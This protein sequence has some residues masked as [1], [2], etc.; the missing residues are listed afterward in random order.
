MSARPA[1]FNIVTRHSVLLE[2]LKAHQTKKLDAF[3]REQDKAIRLALTRDG[4][5]EFKRDRLEALLREV[6]GLLLEINL[7]YTDTLTADLKALSA[8]E[9]SFAVKALEVTGLN[10]V[11]PTVGQLW[12]AA[13]TDPLL[14]HGANKGKLL[15][16]FI[17]DWSSGERTAVSNAIRAAVAQGQTIGETV[18]AIR[19]TEAAG[20]ADGLLSIQKR[21]A[22]AVVRTAV[23]HVGDAS[24]R[25]TYGRN[26]DIVKGEQ[27]SATLDNRTTDIC[28]SL[29]GRVF[30]LD[31]GPRPPAH[32]N[33][34]SVMIPVLNDEFAFLSKGGKRSSPDGPVDAKL[35]YFEWLKTQDK[36]FQDSALG[37]ARATLFREGGLSADRFAALQLDRNFNPLT[38]AEMRTLEPL[39]FDRAG[40]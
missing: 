31:K 14:V 21:Q 4:L 26:A 30:A 3:L 27:W 18:K 28:M 2:R 9:G 32:I 11:T 6:D 10:V 25:E 24:R 15:E 8:H 34:R 7:K 20:F 1:L 38:L 36:P 16:A 22:E 33:C 40:L 29:D 13:T 23:S 35:T 17:S 39:A 12:A 5:T 37:P 19:G